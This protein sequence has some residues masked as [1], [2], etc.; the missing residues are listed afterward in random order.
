[1]EE[2]QNL[3]KKNNIIIRNTLKNTILILLEITTAIYSVCARI[4]YADVGLVQKMIIENNI[5]LHPDGGLSPTVQYMTSESGFMENFRMYWHAIYAE[6][7]M[8]N[9]GS[10]EDFKNLMVWKVH[11]TTHEDPKKNKYLERYAQQLINMF[12]SENL[13]YSIE[14]VEDDSFTRFLRKHKKKPDSLNLLASLF[15]LAEGINIPIKIERN[16]KNRGNKRII[17]QDSEATGNGFYVNLSLI[18]KDGKEWYKKSVYQKKTKEIVNFFKS[19]VDPE[20]TLEVSKEF[21]M[22]T[23]YEEFLTGNF[24]CNP[25]F[26]IQSYIFEY[27]DSA[28][29]YKDFV[30]AVYVMLNTRKPTNYE[31]PISKHDRKVMELL[32]RLFAINNVLDVDVHLGM[33]DKRR[34]FTDFCNFKEIKDGFK[35]IPFMDV[36]YKPSHIDGPDYVN[37]DCQY[38]LSYKDECCFKNCQ[39]CILLAL[40][41]CFTF[42]QETK[43]Y[44]IDHIPNPSKELK[45]FFSKYTHKVSSIGST[46]RS[47]WERVIYGLPRPEHGFSKDGSTVSTG[48]LHMLYTMYDLV[49]NGHRIK[50]TIRYIKNDFQMDYNKNRRETKRKMRKCLKKVFS[51]LSRNKALGMICNDLMPTSITRHGVR[52]T[53][54]YIQISIL[55]DFDSRW[56]G[57]KFTVSTSYNNPLVEIIEKEKEKIDE[58]SFFESTDSYS[59][60]EDDKDLDCYFRKKNRRISRYEP[61]PNDNIYMDPKTYPQMIIKQYTSKRYLVSW[62]DTSYETKETFILKTSYEANKREIV[63]RKCDDPNGLLLWGSLDDLEYKSQLIKMFLIHNNRGFLG[64]DNSMVQFTSNLIRDVPMD[65]L[66]T[67]QC[68][69]SACAYTNNYKIYYPQLIEYDVY[70]IPKTEISS[71]GLSSSMETLSDIGAIDTTSLFN[72]YIS[73]LRVYKKDFAIPYLFSDLPVIISILNKINSIVYNIVHPKPKTKIKLYG[74]EPINQKT[75]SV[76]ELCSYRQTVLN[77]IHNELIDAVPSPVNDN[78]TAIYVCWLFNLINSHYPF[79]M[80]DIK[81]IYVRIN[82]YALS[83]EIK[84]ILGYKLSNEN[85]TKFITFLQ[86]N[87]LELVDNSNY[88]SEEKYQAI[89]FLFNDYNPNKILFM[90]YT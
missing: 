84:G 42:D 56:Y 60:R 67:R 50:R 19:L 13:A 33:R 26:L 30:R 10:T 71:N 85:I 4:G 76:K 40:F 38:T 31:I 44:N 62:G 46:M 28:K 74:K 66:K 17:L 87:K 29:M 88:E 36:I 41:L 63:N 72:S 86:D 59:S 47:D 11:I 12:P 2:R 53:D 57:I 5:I 49:G 15:L 3:L 21:A 55:Y 79:G 16:E 58:T 35:N 51:S 27:I 39:K 48:L 1:M 8:K 70:T 61:N 90:P 43:E 52:A 82:P 77:N 20:N 6:N 14:S 37:K 65:D 89:I 81:P 9:S 75:M 23:T 80:V 69:L 34:N 73:I 83:N 32:N 64:I 54:A 68:I 22:P 7:K 25:R 78:L 45:E 18:I 24:L